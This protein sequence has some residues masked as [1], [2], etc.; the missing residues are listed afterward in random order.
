MDKKCGNARSCRMSFDAS[1][2]ADPRS[3]NHRRIRGDVSSKRCIPFHYI[4]CLPRLRRDPAEEAGEIVNDQQPA[5]R[6]SEGRGPLA[7]LEP[8]H[9]DQ[10]PEKV[11]DGVLTL[12]E[13]SKIAHTHIVLPPRVPNKTVRVLCWDNLHIIEAVLNQVTVAI[14]CGYP[15][16]LFPLPPWS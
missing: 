13:L 2:N 5:R 3:V 7:H 1:M 11:F 8:I 6:S 14:C 16:W 4:N 15:L 12:D 10:S 9:M